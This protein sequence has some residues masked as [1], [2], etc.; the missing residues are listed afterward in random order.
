MTADNPDDFP[1]VPVR[2][3]VDPA[4][5]AG[6]WRTAMGL[7]E[8]DGLHPSTYAKQLAREHV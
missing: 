7:Q 5:R 6:Y 1:Y 3:P 4:V 2:E 8:V